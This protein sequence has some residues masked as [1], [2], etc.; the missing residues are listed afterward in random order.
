MNRCWPAMIILLAAALAAAGTPVA[1]QM[2]IQGFVTDDRGGPLPS[3][4]VAVRIFAAAG[5]GAPVYD[6]A[7]E[8]AGAVTAGRLDIVVGAAAPLLLDDAALYWLELQVGDDE[9]IGDA[10][11][12]RW[13]FRPGTGSHAR[14]D[15]EARLAALEAA[16]GAAR[17]ADARGPAAPPAPPPA[18]KATAFSCEHGLL[19]LGRIAGGNGGFSVEANLLQQPVG[20]FAHGAR[21]ALLGPRYLQANAVPTGASDGTPARF[22]LHACRPNP[23][24]PR[25]TIRYDLPEAGPFASREPTSAAAAQRVGPA[26]RRHG[27]AAAVVERVG[28]RGRAVE[29]HVQVVGVEGVADRAAGAAAGSDP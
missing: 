1:Q 11:A 15:L 10:A 16:L 20:V 24:N 26:A 9:L 19:G 7:A 14:P 25:T 29:D 23:F 17:A 28:R 13:S 3:G 21:G 27:A 2:P 18:V 8:F 4:D 5:G 6:S 12:G 22:A